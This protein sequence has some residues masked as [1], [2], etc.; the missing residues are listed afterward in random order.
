MVSGLK[1]HSGL[2]LSRHLVKTNSSGVTLTNVETDVGS[3]LLYTRSQHV[4]G[5]DVWDSTLSSHKETSRLT[6]TNVE[7]PSLSIVPLKFHSYK[8]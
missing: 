3:H 7:T 4:T 8:Y 2:S 6:L 5:P 1:E